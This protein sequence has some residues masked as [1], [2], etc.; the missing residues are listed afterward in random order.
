MSSFSFPLNPPTV[1]TSSASTGTAPTQSTD[2]DVA[3]LGHGIITP[4]QRDQ[5][6]DFAN[7]GG[8]RLLKSVA[9][10]ILGMRARGGGVRGEL[11]WRQN[12]GSKL[13]RL[14]FKKGVVL[15]ELARVYTQEALAAHDP[16]I[17]VSRAD[18]SFD[19]VTRLQLIRV[20]LD[21]I[22][23]NVAGNQVLLKDVEVQVAL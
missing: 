14:K 12:L 18:V 20:Y 23:E 22:D 13:D 21:L 8:A 16:R 2:P 11:P 19:P 6:T 1:V 17:R 10:Q 5:K 15:Q 3:F 4:F 7:A 9:G